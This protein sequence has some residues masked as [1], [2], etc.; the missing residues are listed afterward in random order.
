MQK[1]KAAVL[2]FTTVILSLLLSACSLT[3]ADYCETVLNKCL[4]LEVSVKELSNQISSKD[5]E[6][7]EETY[8]KNLEEINE[9]LNEL[10]DLGDCRGQRYLIDSAINYAQTYKDIYENEFATALEILKKENRTY[11][12]GDTIAFMIDGIAEK[13]Q[14]AK[15][16]LVKSFSQFVKDFELN[17]SY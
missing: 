12:D 8:N 16:G 4:D 3:P 1:T 7:I 17:A 13:S 6:K 10:Q 2:A 15:C 9:T 14:D 5:Y 11:E